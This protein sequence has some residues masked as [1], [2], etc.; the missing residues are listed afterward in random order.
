MADNL[1]LRFEYDESQGPAF[2]EVARQW[3]VRGHDEFCSEFAASIIRFGAPEFTDEP[4]ER[5]PSWQ[6]FGALVFETR[7][8]HEE[9]LLRYTAQHWAWLQTALTESATRAWL[10]FHWLH[11]QGT[12]DGYS[13]FTHVRAQRDE[14]SPERFHT[15]LEGQRRW[16]YDRDAAN[17]LIDFMTEFADKLPPKIA[18]SSAL[19]DSGHRNTRQRPPFDLEAYE[20]EPGI[21]ICFDWLTYAPAHVVT[22]LGGHAAVRASTALHDVRALSDGAA[23]LVATPTASQY[24]E[25]AEARLGRFLKP[26]LPPREYWWDTHLTN[27]HRRQGT[28]RPVRLTQVRSMT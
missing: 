21:L 12:R 26:V 14:S 2:S 16:L 4:Q 22:A 15:S 25:Q 23:I 8:T 20:D 7:P 3:L 5:D 19:V 6:A 18:Y 10:T 11:D 17:R 27:P 9:T 28:H 24:T 13:F 1:G